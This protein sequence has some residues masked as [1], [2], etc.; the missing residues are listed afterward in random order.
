VD[1]VLGV[2][3]ASPEDLHPTPQWITGP[4]AAVFSGLCR[5]EGRL[6]LIL[7][8][9]ALLSLGEEVRLRALEVHP[10][11]GGGASVAEPGGG[12]AT[13]EGSG[14]ATRPESTILDPKDAKG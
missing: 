3:R 5:R 14:R 6:V 7:D 12:G 2:H 13:G 11:G 9:S 8:L 10:A 1:R 4:E